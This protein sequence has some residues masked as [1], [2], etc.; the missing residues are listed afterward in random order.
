MSAKQTST[1]EPPLQ[2]NKPPQLPKHN[3]K[4][5]FLHSVVSF[6]SIISKRP[7]NTVVG[8]PFSSDFQTQKE[9]AITIGKGASVYFFLSGFC[10]WGYI[11]AIHQFPPTTKQTLPPMPPHGWFLQIFFDELRLILFHVSDLSILF[12]YVFM[13]CRLCHLFNLSAGFLSLGIGIRIH[14]LTT[15]LWISLFSYSNN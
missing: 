15:L 11:S 10:I 3:P 2:R 7:W 9:A 1:S 12:V 6:I 13:L 4:N 8:E 14:S 5:S